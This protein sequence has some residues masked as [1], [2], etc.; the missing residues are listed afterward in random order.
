MDA[1]ALKD[2]MTSFIGLLGAEVTSLDISTGHRTVV[3]IASPDAK[4][5][6]GPDGDHLRAL[7]TVAKRLVEAKYGEEAASFLIDVNRFYE[8]K[9]DAVRANASM[10][11]QRARL[12]KHDVELGPMSA[13]ER[14]VVHELFSEDPEI[15]TESQGEGKFRH[16]VLKYKEGSKA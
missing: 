15:K 14:L 2:F 6:I 1:A 11:A 4:E 16:I 13:Y 7:N 5:L 9:M 12:F 8:E 3:A 10:L